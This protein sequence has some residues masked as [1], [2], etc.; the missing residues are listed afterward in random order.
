MSDCLGNTLWRIPPCL[1]IKGLDGR[2]LRSP[3]RHT[4]SGVMAGSDPMT[5]LLT[6]QSCY[7]VRTAAVHRA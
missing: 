4:E 2:D 1:S 5:A 3:S 6:W 7:T